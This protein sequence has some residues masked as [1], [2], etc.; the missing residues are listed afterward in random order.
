TLSRKRS[1]STRARCEHLPAP[2][3]I[4]LALRLALGDGV[5]LVGA[6]LALGDADLDLHPPILE[7]HAQGDERV[8]GLLLRLLQL[9][10]L[11]PVEKQ[12]ARPLRVVVEQRPCRLVGRD[13]RVD[14]IELA[15]FRYRIRVRQ[16][17]AALAQALHFRPGESDAGLDLALD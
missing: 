7:V 13:L 2:G 4:H 6:G 1:A 8:A 12:L 9:V 3:A 15:I 16:L 5:A 14:E 17:R 11:A 10:D